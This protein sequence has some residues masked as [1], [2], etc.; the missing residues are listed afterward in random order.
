MH[1]LPLGDREAT[2]AAADLRRDLDFGG[3]DDA[4]GARR[5]YTRAQ[6]QEQQYAGRAG[7]R[8]QYRDRMGTLLGV[9]SNE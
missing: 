4:R 2:Q 8:H 3:L 1:A 9:G 5:R 6:D 7:K